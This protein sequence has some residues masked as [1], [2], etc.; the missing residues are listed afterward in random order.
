MA[1]AVADSRT[2]AILGTTTDPALRPPV[3]L[4]SSGAE[5]FFQEAKIT[6]AMST[7]LRRKFN[8]FCSKVVSPDGGEVETFLTQTDFCQLMQYYKATKQE[9]FE[10]FFQAM[11]RNRDGK[12]NFEEF[13]L[14]CCAAD[15]GTHHI[16]NSF[17]G[18]ERSRYIFDFYDENRSGALEFDEFARLTAGCLKVR[19]TKTHLIS[20]TVKN[21]AVHKAQELGALCQSSSD[22][23]SFEFQ[24][25]YES[26]RSERLR[27]TARLFRFSKSMLEAPGDRRRGASVS[28]TASD[29]ADQ[30][31]HF[32]LLLLAVSLAP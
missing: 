22:I 24:K 14:G 7:E 32:G 17:T 23:A 15:V 19:T 29:S 3:E 21:I 6:L 20:E 4:S 13:L 8:E 1:S 5:S 27:G 30:R 10:Q 2:P 11:D 31:S 9:R 28:T 26:V 12:L 16:L 18:Y 25:F